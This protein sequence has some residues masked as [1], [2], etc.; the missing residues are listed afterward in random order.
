MRASVSSTEDRFKATFYAW[1]G[2]EC[3][4][5]ARIQIQ[6]DLSPAFDIL[7]TLKQL[8]ARLTILELSFARQ[9]HLGRATIWQE[10]PP[11]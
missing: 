5:I 7:E 8:D 6:F 10:C 4:L 2:R 3:L 1:I 9:M 11:A